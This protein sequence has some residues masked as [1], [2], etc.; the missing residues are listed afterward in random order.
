MEIGNDQ[1]SIR[2][3]A[4]IIRLEPQ[5]AQEIDLRPVE[6]GSPEPYRTSLRTAQDDKASAYRRTRVRAAEIYA[7]LAAAMMKSNW[8]MLRALNLRPDMARNVRRRTRPIYI[9]LFWDKNLLRI[10]K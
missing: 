3:R 10:N 6:R 8:S 9:A 4:A 7:L 5:G 2:L 1:I